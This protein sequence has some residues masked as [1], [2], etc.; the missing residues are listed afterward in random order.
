MGP[1]KS[2]VFKEYPG[3]LAVYRWASGPSKEAQ[4]SMYRAVMWC[5]MWNTQNFSPLSSFDFQK[6][7]CEGVSFVDDLRGWFRKKRLDRNCGREGGS[8]NP[9]L[10]F[11][12]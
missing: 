12:L 1:D 4:Y 9:E 6:P 2:T 5:A 7:L 3:G 8:E 10:A 11:N